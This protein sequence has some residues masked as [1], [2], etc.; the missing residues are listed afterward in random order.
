MDGGSKVG[1]GAAARGDEAEAE[2][3][4]DEAGVPNVASL[5]F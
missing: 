1:A 3:D 4:D 2:D 5:D